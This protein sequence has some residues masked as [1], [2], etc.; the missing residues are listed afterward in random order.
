MEVG[1]GTIN[2]IDGL[3]VPKAAPIIPN[4]TLEYTKDGGVTWQAKNELSIGSVGDRQVQV[5]SR[6]FG[7][8]RKGSGF[9][10]RLTVTDEVP[11]EM[12]ELWMDI[13]GGM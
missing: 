6:L 9:G 4:M 8:V 12:Y 7:R 13:E 10:L 11:V 5:I 2:N 3:G 1:V